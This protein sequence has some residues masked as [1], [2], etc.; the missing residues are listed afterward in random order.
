MFNVG[1]TG[2]YTENCISRMQSSMTHPVPMLMLN[3]T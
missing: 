3:A 1:N 2:T